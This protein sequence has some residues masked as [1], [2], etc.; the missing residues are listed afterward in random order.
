MTKANHGLGVGLALAASLGGILFGY[1]TAVMSGLTDAV[2]YNFV[3]GRHLAETSANTL[4]GFAISCALLG[5][6]VGAAI[7]G[8]LSTSVGRRGGLIIAGILFFVSSLGAGYPEFFFSLFGG[9]GY[10]ALP[11]FIFYRLIGGVAI[12]MASTLVSL[13]IAEVAPPSRRGM[14]GTF[15]QIAIMLGI[16]L[17]YFVNWSIQNGRDRQFLMDT[18]WRR[19]LAAAAVPATL[20]TLSMLFMPETPRF[21]VLKGRSAEA[22]GLLERLEGAE[23]AEAT[24]KQIEETLVERSR[25]VWSFGALVVVVGIMLSVF[26]QFIGI[27]AVLYFSTK[28][29]ENMGASPNEAFLQ[30]ALYVGVTMTLATLIA[31]FLVDRIGRKPLLIAGG[32]VMAVAMLVLGTLFHMHIVST[33]PGQAGASGTTGSSYLGIAV[34]MVYVIAFSSSWGPVTWV[35]L[36]EIFPNSIKSKAMSIAVA[37]QWIS[38]FLVTQSFYM[39]DR[40]THLVAEFNHGFAY[41]VYGGSCVLASLFVMRFVPETKGR[42]LEGI[43]KLWHRQTPTGLKPEAALE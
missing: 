27:N 25:P 35:M 8:P 17:S 5:C 16:N 3:A 38:N 6:V 2:T 37:A 39:M 31:T 23:R 11:A 42:A 24:L 12:G 28:M 13:Y 36:S 10:R 18:G 7:T 14:L 32:L 33:T 20:M 26:Q 9:E 1:D 19:M 15:N 29:F 30:S 21:L 4:S 41:W 43:E 22:L 40:S 34:V